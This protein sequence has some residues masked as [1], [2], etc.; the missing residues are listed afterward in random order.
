MDSNDSTA[1]MT[2]SSDVA[3]ADG[4]AMAV[5]TRTQ[6]VIREVLAV[7]VQQVGMETLD[8]LMS[9][10]VRQLPSDLSGDHFSCS[11]NPKLCCFDT[12]C[13]PDCAWTCS[14]LC[15]RCALFNRLIQGKCCV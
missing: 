6:Q 10:E 5:L 13:L 12:T 1:S 11:N 3:L 9:M 14:R 2:S 8:A 15:E 7:D 4:G